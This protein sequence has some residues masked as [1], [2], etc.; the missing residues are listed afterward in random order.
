VS[1][2]NCWFSIRIDLLAILLILTFTLVCVFTRAS[3]NPVVLS[4]L[5]SYV[6]TIQYTLTQSLKTYMSLQ[7]TMVN[8][9]RCVAMLEIPQERALAPGAPDQLA[10]RP[11]WPENGHVEFKDVC[12]KY[13]P[14]TETVLHDLSFDVQPGQKIGVVGRTGAGKSTV[15]LAIARIVEIFA[16][17][18]W[19]DGVDIQHVSLSKLRSSITIIPQDA[20]MFTGTLRFNLDPLGKASDEEI[21]EL[22]EAA[23]LTNVLHADEKGLEQHISE[24]GANLSSGERQLICICRAILRK[25]KLVVLD[26]A[27]ANIDMVTE[28][29]IQELINTQFKDATMLTIAHR[30]NTIIKSDKV[31]VLSFGR[32]KEFDSPQNL[33]ADPASE[34]S[35]LL[36]ELE[37]KEKE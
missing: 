20:T 29:K 17:R 3:T 4:M 26:E 23:S 6:L 33:M 36:K 30:L 2:V 5:L 15:T 22:L 32:I 24:N 34:F 12:L 18:I 28:Q 16:G 35:Q 8:A 25:G 27:T 1:G 9:N 37:K 31:L 7:S 11:H 10:N 19:I 14:T 13:R 21:V